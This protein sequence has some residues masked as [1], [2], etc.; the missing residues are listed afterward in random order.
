MILSILLGLPLCLQAQ[1][2][3][4]SEPAQEPDP[5]QWWEQLSTEEQEAMQRRLEK[6]RGLPE[7][8]R[9]EMERRKE[10]FEKEKS[11]VLQNMSA[12][13]RAAYDA[14]EKREQRRFLR[15]RVH[16]NLRARGQDLKRKHPEMK[17]GREG[18]EKIRRKQVREGLERAATDGWIGE[19][20]IKWLE[21]AP[22]HEQMAVLMEVRK[23][24]VLESAARRGLWEELGLDERE[25][26]RFS[27]LPAP[28]F[29][30]ELRM[31]LGGP[32]GP[33]RPGEMEARPEGPPPRG[34]R[35]GRGGGREHQGRGKKG[36]GPG[37]PGERPVPARPRR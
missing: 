2:T 19:H 10:V 36:P 31:A 11:A 4:A 26:I 27:T 5:Q 15:D 23:W 1:E 3:A 6:M 9:A 14:M 16:Q 13:E 18:F 34:P 29:F 25:Q 28:E 12:E 7:D 22:L 32:G 37:G 33:G 17:E 30:H 35:G 20:A 24:E 21:D 8:K